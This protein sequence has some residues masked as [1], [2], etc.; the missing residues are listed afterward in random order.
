MANSASLERLERIATRLML[1]RQAEHAIRDGESSWR[2][3]MART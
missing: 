2:A 1:C 3:I